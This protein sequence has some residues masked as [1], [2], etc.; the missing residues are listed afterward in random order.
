MSETETTVH[1]KEDLG[2]NKAWL[3]RKFAEWWGYRADDNPN[4]L[5]AEQLLDRR[6]QT[7]TIDEAEL[8]IDFI[9]SPGD[10][11]VIGYPE[12]FTNVEITATQ[13][14][15]ARYDSA[16]AKLEEIKERI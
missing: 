10:S 3:K 12:D 8:L 11:A 5:Q 13:K 7:Y 14:A 15:H 2:V 1:L 9:I 4:W 6:G 16:R